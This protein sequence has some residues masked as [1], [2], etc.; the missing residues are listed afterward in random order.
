MVDK[1]TRSKKNAP[2]PKG[3][4]TATKQNLKKCQQKNLVMLYEKKK[5]DSYI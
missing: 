2:P 3:Q 4:K 1:K 5:S